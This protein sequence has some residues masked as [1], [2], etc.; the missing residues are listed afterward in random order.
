VTEDQLTSARANARCAVAAFEAIGVYANAR[1]QPGEIMVIRRQG[2]HQLDHDRLPS[3]LSALSH[4][5]DSIPQVRFADVLSDAHKEYSRQRR[6]GSHPASARRAAL[7]GQAID[8]YEHSAA[9]PR[10]YQGSLWPPHTLAYLRRDASRQGLGFEAAISRLSG[11]LLT[12]LHH[13]ADRQGIDFETAMT[14]GRR[15][16]ARERLSAE[17]RFGTGRDPD[18]SP[19]TLLAGPPTAPPFTPVATNQG[20]VTEVG[21]A[22]WHLIRTAAR[23]RGGEQRRFP[24]AH[25]DDLDDMHV[26][27]D[28]L[29]ETCGLT[30][31]E[32][33]GRLAS[34]IADR[35][36]E[37]ER[38]PA[39]AAEL[40]REHGRTGAQPYCGL[41]TDGDATA[42][43]RAFGETEWMTEANRPYRLALVT[44]Y[45]EAYRQASVQ[46][47]AA[48]ISPARISA[49]DFPQHTGQQ[50]P[51][52]GVP[53]NPGPASQARLK[54]LPC[55]RRGRA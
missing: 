17:G 47:P 26:L 32:V 22:E 1:L 4:L 19:G 53:A 42:L 38:G 9:A 49:R 39:A 10:R 41:D 12:D 16:H 11:A 23:L 51:H 14:A 8:V 3:L 46:C 6:D 21:D 28:A 18:A 45:A 13:Y 48:A 50:P 54:P 7:A 35:A 44:A 24:G 36:A 34:R 43:L 31:A 37:M 20:V 55:P 25:L 30:R 33:V 2:G 29:G 52:D 5:A 40:G 15:A 27:A